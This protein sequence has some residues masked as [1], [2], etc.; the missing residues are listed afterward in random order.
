ME[1]HPLGLS[2]ICETI[3]NTTLAQSRLDCRHD[4]TGDI[5][6]TLPKSLRGA[7]NSDRAIGI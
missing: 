7:E 5:K 6:R 1:L 3:F 2:K 4:F